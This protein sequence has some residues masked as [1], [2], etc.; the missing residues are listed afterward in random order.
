MAQKIQSGGITI[1]QQTSEEL[2]LVEAYGD[3]GFRLMGRRVE[4]ATLVNGEGFYPVTAKTVAELSAQS[5]ERVADATKRPD[6]LLVGTGA[7]M[8]LLPAAMRQY[9]EGAGIGFDIMDTG[10]AARTYNVLLMEGRK[11]A[12]LLLPVE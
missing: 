6:I 5:F 3:G 10:A 4:G 11:V 2:L 1:E 7:R 8:Q 9:L 12:A